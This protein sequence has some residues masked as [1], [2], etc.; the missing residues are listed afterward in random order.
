MKK[1]IVS[2][3]LLSLLLP[4]FGGCKKIGLTSVW[5]GTVAAAFQKGDGSEKKPYRIKTAAQLAFLAQKVNEGEPYEGKYF[6]LS[7]NI[8]LAGLEWTPI[9]YHENV[10]RGLFDGKGHSVK[11]MKITKGLATTQPEGSTWVAGLFGDCR[12]VSLQNLTISDATI[13]L[14]IDPCDNGFLFV[15]ALAGRIQ[16]PQNIEVSGIRVRKTTLKFHYSK[17]LE[18]SEQWD[19]WY[20]GGMIGAISYAGGETAHTLRFC[21]N[22]TDLRVEAP[23]FPMYDYIPGFEIGGLVGYFRS[24]I[25]FRIENCISSLDV[26]LDAKKQTLTGDEHRAYPAIN[27]GA[28]GSMIIISDSGKVQNIFSKIR[29]NLFYGGESRY[30]ASYFYAALSPRIVLPEEGRH[31]YTDFRFENLFGFVEPQNPETGET[32]E[33]EQQIFKVKETTYEQVGYTK[34]NCRVCRSLPQDCAFPRDVFNL[35]DPENPKLK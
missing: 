13:D 24:Y 16:G 30:K 7:R 27:L 1:L 34:T 3:L 26:A 29:T 35:R 8:D 23:S 14:T 9:G 10:F 33:L 4:A 28:F 22:E 15:G 17:P 11:N 12:S 21:N 2:L 20:I 18:K 5:D 6:E 19:D 32:Q 25:P 31:K